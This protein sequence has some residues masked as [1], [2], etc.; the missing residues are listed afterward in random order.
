MNKN[1]SIL[2]KQWTYLKSKVFGQNNHP[3]TFHLQQN[4]NMQKNARVGVVLSIERGKK[5]GEH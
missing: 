1:E 4:S 3:T 5:H 2:G